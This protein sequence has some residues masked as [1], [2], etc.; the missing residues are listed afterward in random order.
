[1][2]GNVLVEIVKRY[3]YYEIRSSNTYQCYFLNMLILV[4]PHLSIGK[5][6]IIINWI[7]GCEGLRV[8]E[9]CVEDEE[10]PFPDVKNF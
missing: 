8:I 4:V 5:K 10:M 9:A 7:S 2:L 3:T 6:S 1:M